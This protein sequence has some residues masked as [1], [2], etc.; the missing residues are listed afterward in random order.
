MRKIF[1]RSAFNYDANMVS[2]ETGTCCADDE[3]KTVQ[4]FKEEADI[5][6]LVRR[7]GITG[8]MPQGIVPP[9]YGVF[10][11]VFD[12][13]TAMDAIAVARESF[14]AMPGDVRAKFQNDPQKF[15]EFCSNK[16]NLP[17]MRKMGLAIPEVLDDN[18]SAASLPGKE[19]VNH[20]GDTKSGVTGSGKAS[21]GS[22]EVSSSK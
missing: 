1:V 14:D 18:V 15:V 3:D 13:K 21:E 6:V 12:F 17:E 22:G 10:E 5:N 9:T 2:R 11:D 20:E 8:Q 16:D 7:F 4:S 19:K